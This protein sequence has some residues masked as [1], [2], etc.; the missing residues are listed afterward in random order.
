MGRFVYDD[1][2]D[3]EESL[4]AKVSDGADSSGRGEPSFSE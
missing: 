4:K 2:L 3:S 1:L